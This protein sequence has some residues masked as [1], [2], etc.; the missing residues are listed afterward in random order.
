[1]LDALRLEHLVHGVG[2]LGQAGIDIAADVL[3]D[4]Q[5]VAGGVPHRDRRVGLECGDRIGDRRVHLVGHVDDGGRGTC[6]LARLGDDD[7]QHVAGEAGAAADRNHD[8]PVLVDDADQQLARQVG[9]GEHRVHARHGQRSTGV[10]ADDVGTRVRGEVQRGVQHA[11]DAHVVDIATIAQRQLVGL[12]LDSAPTDLARQL[13]RELL[14]AGDGLDGVEH[15]HVPGAAAQVRTEVAA[16]VAAVQLG[17][18][19]VDLRLGPHDDARNAEAALQAA[20]RG[21]RIGERA[22][23]RPRRRPRA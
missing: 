17:A 6:Q 2:R 4:A 13:R 19:L 1:M 10:D 22:G 18:L 12:V 9:R 23:A 20:A 5:H 14:A 11:V 15:L 21:E 16:H 8:R 7:R 3:A